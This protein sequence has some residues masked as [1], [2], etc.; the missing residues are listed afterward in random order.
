MTV[1][2]HKM[3]DNRCNLSKY[4]ALK[5]ILSDVQLLILCSGGGSPPVFEIPR[6][7]TDTYTT[8]NIFYNAFCSFVASRNK[9]EKYLWSRHF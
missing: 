9:K 8:E 3:T 6:I 4:M 2:W 1:H 5:Q 7:N